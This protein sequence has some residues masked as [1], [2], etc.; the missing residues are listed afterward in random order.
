MKINI[1]IKE[2]K[3]VTT[4]KEFELPYFVKAHSF[5]QVIAIIEENEVISVICEKQIHSISVMTNPVGFNDYFN[6]KL[7]L[8]A[9]KDEFYEAMD[10]TIQGIGKEM[11]DFIGIETS[12]LP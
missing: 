11:A 3:V 10:E 4:T 5:K 8:P 6:P 2:K 9:T 1:D 12:L 7:Y